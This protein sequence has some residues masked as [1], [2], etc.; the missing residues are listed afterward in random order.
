MKP[1][2]R[3]VSI[4]IPTHDRRASLERTLRALTDQTYPL[5]HVEVV[6]VADGCTDT[7]RDASGGAWP[8][9]LRVIEQPRLGPAAARNR[10]AAATTGEILV[11]LDDDIE[12]FPGFLAAHVLA[13]AGSELVVGIGYLPAQ[14]QGRRDFFA[15]MFERM[16]EPGRRYV[17]SDLLSGNF[18]IRRALFTR[19]GGFNEALRCHEDYELGLR[20]IAADARL[21]FVPAAAGWHHE[22]TG[23]D[24][25]L[26]RKRDEGRADVVLARGYPA[27]AP[28]LPLSSPDGPSTFRGRVLKKLALTGPWA[29]DLIAAVCRSTMPLFEAAKL[30]T[31]WRRL[32]D[33]LLS[34]W[35][36]RGVG[37]SL[38]GA[39]LASVR[40]V[41]VSHGGDAR[42]L[43]LEPGLH[44]AMVALD[45]GAAPAAIR[46]RWGSLVVGT[47]APQPGAEP[48]RGRHLPEL[49]RTRFAHA[50]A[51]TLALAELLEKGGRSEMRPDQLLQANAE[52]RP[53]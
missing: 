2:E 33:D 23:L 38:H 14:V 21:Q 9:S 32:L 46:L 31:R 43:D 52:K 3:M 39:P 50:L 10:G 17:Y 51:D 44:A 18:S 22:H 48:L 1:L 37:E 45:A 35:Y 27:L 53:A 41:S 11:F 47:V 12:P 5:A 8:F 7:T 19:V 49:L 15:N 24:R 25:A 13:H 6:V 40:R 28:A 16:R 4:V 29:G 26:R 36:W 20:L 34:Y 30:R 42:D